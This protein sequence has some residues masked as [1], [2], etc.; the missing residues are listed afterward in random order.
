M[1]EMT[2]VQNINICN[3]M[4]KTTRYS[5][6]GVAIALSLYVIPRNKIELNTIL[7]VTVIATMIYVILDTPIFNK[8]LQ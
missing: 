7:M 5:L 4:V 1:T 8:E 6:F 2:E 3:V